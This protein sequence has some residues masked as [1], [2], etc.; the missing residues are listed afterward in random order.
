[1]GEGTVIG[2][3]EAA[4]LD[5]D[6]VEG[7]G[8]IGEIALG[9]AEEGGRGIESGGGFGGLLMG[10]VH[11]GG[12]DGALGIPE[13]AEAPFNGGEGFD[14]EELDVVG[15]LEVVEEG[16]E[17]GLEGIVVLGGEADGFGGGRVGE[18]GLCEWGGLLRTA[19]KEGPVAA[20]GGL[21]RG[22]GLATGRHGWF[23]PVCLEE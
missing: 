23:A 19:A 8:G 10:A 16:V 4:F 5:L 7:A 21:L 14:A 12:E 20:G 18:E 11:L 9:A 1:M 15:G 6:F 3:D 13:A 17:E 2:A 22:T